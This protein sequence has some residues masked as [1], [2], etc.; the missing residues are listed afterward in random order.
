MIRSKIRGALPWVGAL[1][2]LVVL[3]GWLR[4]QGEPATTLSPLRVPEASL[5]FG[6]VA[7]QKDLVL[8]VPVVNDG[9]EDV[10]VVRLT[11][12]CLC[13]RVEPESFTVPAGGQTVVRITLDLLPKSARELEQPYREIE[14]QLTFELAGD[15]AHP[16][17]TLRG[18]VVAPF[19]VSPPFAQFDEQLVVGG[20]FVACELE[21]RSRQP[22]AGL[23]GRCD[24]RWASVEALPAD[25]G[26]YRLLVRPNP[27]LPV[28]SH[29]FQVELVGQS[30]DGHSLAAQPV[31]VLAHVVSDIQTTPRAVSYGLLAKDEPTEREIVFSSRFGRELELVEVRVPEGLEVSAQPTSSASTLTVRLVARPSREGLQSGLVTFVLRDSAGAKR[32][33]SLRT[34]LEV[35]PQEADEALVSP[36]LTR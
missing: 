28:G 25:D 5:N 15:A 10:R 34:S 35:R 1:L 16:A 20:E 29:Q 26:G 7:A 24:P 9:E 8:E 31:P 32:E 27:A 2:P 36:Q 30:G 22:L 11:P 4:A 13:T 19:E 33:V 6:E 17:G 21:V 18:R 12:S 3:A 14:H 23:T